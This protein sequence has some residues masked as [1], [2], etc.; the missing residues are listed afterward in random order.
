M[1]FPVTSP[2]YVFKDIAAGPSGGLSTINQS[3]HTGGNEG[4]FG[5]EVPE[6]A[7]FGFMGAGLIAFAVYRRK[8]A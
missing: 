6:P 7:T 2:I 1:T 4:N 8:S 5:N 3:F